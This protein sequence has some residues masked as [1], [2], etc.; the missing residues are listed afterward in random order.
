MKKK[1]VILI[2]MPFLLVGCNNQ[3][4]DLKN[5]YIAMKS[6]LLDEASYVIEN[7]L[8]LEIT[9]SIDRQNEETVNYK[10]LLSRP[11]ENMHNIKAMVV[12]NYNNEDVFPSIGIFDEPL[13]LST[14]SEEENQI[15]LKGTIETSKNISKLNLNLKI[16][17]EYV[18]DS[19]ETKD[20]YYKTT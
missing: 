8:P 19:G 9:V 16:W 4:E 18:D 13:N 7:E 1:F 2:L 6:K 12:H 14:T 20:I 10:V 11:K 15:E 3:K 5:Q 17:I